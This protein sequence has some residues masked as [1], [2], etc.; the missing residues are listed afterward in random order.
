MTNRPRLLYSTCWLIMVSDKFVDNGWIVAILMVDRGLL[1]FFVILRVQSVRPRSPICPQGHQSLWYPLAHSSGAN[2]AD[3]PWIGVTQLT[4]KRIQLLRRSP[5]GC[6][7]CDGWYQPSCWDADAGRCPHVNVPSPTTYM[8]L[9]D[10]TSPKRSAIGM[11]FISLPTYMCDSSVTTEIKCGIVQETSR[12]YVARICA[13]YN[14]R[15]SGYLFGRPTEVIA[16]PPGSTHTF[17]HTHKFKEWTL[18]QIAEHVDIVN[19][20]IMYAI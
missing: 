5:D 11:W 1:G 4:S 9:E 12:M 8:K 16:I 18:H 3:P 13:D 20:C 19:T 15:K 10:R 14:T 2:A 7:H 17:M 6:S